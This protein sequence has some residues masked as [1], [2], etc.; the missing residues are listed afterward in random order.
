M[1]TIHEMCRI[2]VSDDEIKDMDATSTRERATLNT[3]GRYTVWIHKATDDGIDS[4]FL[5]FA[6]TLGQAITNAWR[7]IA[8]HRAVAATVK[9]RVG[10]YMAV[11]QYKRVADLNAEGFE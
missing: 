5:A 8:D 1:K 10:D 7:A 6:E 3:F 9:Y 11:C 2:H 4:R